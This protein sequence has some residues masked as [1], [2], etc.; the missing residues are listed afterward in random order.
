MR[1]KDLQMISKRYMMRQFP[2][3]NLIELWAE[4]PFT[5]MDEIFD[6]LRPERMVTRE[7]LQTQRMHYEI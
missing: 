5:Y 6:N 3:N 1:Y 2:F 4:G 7:L